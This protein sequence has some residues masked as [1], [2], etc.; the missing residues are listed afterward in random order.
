MIWRAPAQI[1][2]G[3]LVYVVTESNRQR[4]SNC[5]C[6]CS[7]AKLSYWPKC[8]KCWR[9][10]IKAP[11]EAFKNFYP[12]VLRSRSVASTILEIRTQKPVL[13]IWSEINNKRSITRT[14]SDARKL[15]HVNGPGDC[16]ESLE[17]V[18]PTRCI[19]ANSLSYMQIYFFS[20][21]NSW[22][23]LQIGQSLSYSDYLINT[24]S[25]ACARIHRQRQQAVVRR[26]PIIEILEAHPFSRICHINMLHR[27]E[28]AYTTFTSKAE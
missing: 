14:W 26:K 28:L 23:L 9:P 6:I 7:V 27:S 1:L 24:H 11:S 12:T 2:H 17:T 25:H 20:S 5:I 13:F 16:C 18:P 10:N 15:I 22:Q 4:S 21:A 3:Y 19:L 8:N